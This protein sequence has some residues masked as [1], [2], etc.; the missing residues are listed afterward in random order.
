MLSAAAPLEAAAGPAFA[1]VNHLAA[2]LDL[3]TATA[4]AS[5]RDLAILAAAGLGPYP[6]WSEYGVDAG[7]NNFVMLALAPVER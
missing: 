5:A 2:G 6:N 7:A 3:A 1:S 4:R